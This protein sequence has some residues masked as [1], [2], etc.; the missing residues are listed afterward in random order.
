MLTSLRR[1]GRRGRPTQRASQRSL[2]WPRPLDPPTQQPPDL[3]K[4]P[5]QSQPQVR[6]PGVE[7]TTRSQGDDVPTTSHRHRVTALVAIWCIA[8]FAIIIRLIILQI[9]ESDRLAARASGQQERQIVLEARR[10][11]ITDRDGIDVAISLP[12]ASVA[13]NPKSVNNPG[14]LASAISDATGESAESVLRRIG[15]RA[16]SFAWVARN[17]TP[18]AAA[19][20]Q[21]LDPASM[22]LLASTRRVHPL[23]RLAGQLLGHVDVDNTGGDGLEL[24]YHDALTGQDGWIRTLVD[25]RG[26]RVANTASP[27]EPAIDG[28]DLT[29]TIDADYQAIA[30]HELSLAVEATG[31]TSGLAILYEAATGAIRAMANVP[32]YG[33]D[34]FRITDPGLRTNRAITD[35][36][37]PGSTF[38]IVTASAALAEGV[39]SVDDSIDCLNGSIE[40]AGQR[41]R[42]SHPNSV[43]PFREV[44]SQSSNV[45]TITAAMRLDADVFYRYVRRFGFGAETGIDLPGESKGILAPTSRWSGRSQ[46]TIA[47]GQEISATALQIAAAYGALAND[48]WLMRPYSVSRVTRPDGTVADETVTNRIRQVV[49]KSIA[50]QMV[51]LLCGVVETGTGT[52]ARIAGFRVAGKTGTAQMA[53]SDGRGYEKGAYTASF[54]GFLPD[55]EPRLVCVVSI[56][57]PKSSYYGSTVAGP[58]FKRIMSRIMSRDASIVRAPEQLNV[59][60]MPNLI[61]RTHTQALELCDSLG[62]AARLAGRGTYVI[63]QWPPASSRLPVDRVVDLVVADRDVS[64]PIIPDV[65]QM[66]V[67]EAMRIL[68]TT[69]IPVELRGDGTVFRQEPWPGGRLP[70]GSTVVL[71]CRQPYMPRPT[72][73][74]Q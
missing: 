20:L 21:S 45:G 30:E 9:V 66:T 26:A 29:L 72:G 49:T 50:R 53:R 48:G 18:D 51:D 7:Q 35:P 31:A 33:P 74:S 2:A 37:E 58:V 13:L 39:V 24:L 60:V 47:I 69:G 52:T 16:R 3:D 15:R 43:L 44:F 1:I 63:G 61:G 22:M 4:R 25:A 8:A 19:H 41:I 32:T 11:I 68:S 28:N 56:A 12:A 55:M 46:A 73:A 10:G 5:Q 71:H 59:V 17:I 62:V 40:I 57:R 64:R 27:V 6:A 34:E 65:R 42:D 38:K 36:F 70:S 14:I 23:G 67:R 54:A